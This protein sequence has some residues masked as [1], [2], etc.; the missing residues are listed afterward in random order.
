[1]Y[2]QRKTARGDGEVYIPPNYRGNALYF[3]QLG[4]DTEERCKE[5]PCQSHE[6]ESKEEACTSHPSPPLCCERGRSA[7]PLSGLFG[8]LMEGDTLLI[9]AIVFF[10]FFTGKDKD[11]QGQGCRKD[12][13]GEDNTLLLL[14]LLLLL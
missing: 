9:L 12:A 14:L 3:E 6:S 10:L 5:E 11:K 4:D 13:G 7:S 2:T 1:M 8:K